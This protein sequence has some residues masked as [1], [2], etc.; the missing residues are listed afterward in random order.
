M[1]NES[2]VD[3]T[4]T[5]GDLVNVECEI[6]YFVYG[7]SLMR[8][9]PEGFWEGRPNIPLCEAIKC[10]ITEHNHLRLIGENRYN[11]TVSFECEEGFDLEGESE[12]VCQENGVWSSPIPRCALVDCGEVENID[13]GVVEYT[14]TSYGSTAIYTCA[15]GYHIEGNNFVTCSSNSSWAPSNLACVP[16]RCSGNFTVT[17]GEFVTNSTRYGSEARLICDLGYYPR[18]DVHTSICNEDGYWIPAVSQR[19]INR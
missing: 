18:N 15:T 1:H 8:C 10:P 14:V 19:L 13:N 7:N 4:Y 12:A 16:V 3:R 17:H 9:R 6:G 5:E 11:A 2:D